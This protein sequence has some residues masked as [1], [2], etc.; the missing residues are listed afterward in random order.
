MPGRDDINLHGRVVSHCSG[1][2]IVVNSWQIE[3]RFILAAEACLCA[4]PAAPSIQVSAFKS[5][6]PLPRLNVNSFRAARGTLQGERADFSIVRF[7]LIRRRQPC[8]FL[9]LFVPLHVP[10][11]WTSRTPGNGNPM[12]SVNRWSNTSSHLE[13]PLCLFNPFALARFWIKSDRCGSGRVSSM[14]GRHVTHTNC[15]FCLRNFVSKNIVRFV[16]FIFQQNIVRWLFYNQPPW[17]FVSCCVWVR[18][19]FHEDI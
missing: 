9:L 10:S 8:L 15:L 3:F 7:I 5:A 16:C 6:G 2:N 14:I 19:H 13:T 18:I 4:S 17:S 1:D 11:S 12:K